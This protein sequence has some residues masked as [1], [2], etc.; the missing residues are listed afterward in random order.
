ME[1]FSKFYYMR[2]VTKKRTIVFIFQ[3][4]QR[5]EFMF[6]EKCGVGEKRTIDM[7]RVLSLSL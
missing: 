4:Q 3:K 1:A 2:V 7:Y 5:S 6:A